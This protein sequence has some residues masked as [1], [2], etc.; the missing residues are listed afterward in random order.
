MWHKSSFYLSFKSH[1]LKIS[2]NVSAS[3]VNSHNTVGH[4][5]SF[6]YRNSMC[7]AVACVQHN[8]SHSSCCISTKQARINLLSF[9]YSIAIK[10]DSYKLRTACIDTKS[11]GTLKVSKKI[12]AAFSRLRRGFNGA[13]VNRT[14][15][16]S[17]NV[18]SWC[19]SNEIGSENDTEQ[20]SYNLKALLYYK[21][22]SKFVPYH[23][24]LWLCRVPLD[25]E[26]STIHD[27]PLLS[28]P[29]RYRLRAL[30]PL[31]EHV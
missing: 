2:C 20:F 14:G 8:T 26:C 25:I 24:N 31:H 18:E 4:S 30:Q 29:Q 10:Q 15:C 11:A 13:S 7:Y 16:S 28:V 6:V 17:L 23:S 5:K 9:Y 19:C 22:S 21:C 3:N 1:L 27:V 12:S